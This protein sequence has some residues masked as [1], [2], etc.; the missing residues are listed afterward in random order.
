ML[1]QIFNKMVTF[2]QLRSL[3]RSVPLCVGKHVGALGLSRAVQWSLSY[4]VRR[5]EYVRKDLCQDRSKT[6][7]MTKRG[8]A[9]RKWNCIL[10]HFY[11]VTMTAHQPV[12]LL[13]KTSF[14]LNGENKHK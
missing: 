14:R 1:S 8:Q 4:F 10:T 6:T 5:S 12:G 9:S 7:A 11:I 2:E 13:Y 3:A